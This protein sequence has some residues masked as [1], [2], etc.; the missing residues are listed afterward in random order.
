MSRV[1][2]TGGA[3]FI[4]SRLVR[5]LLDAGR[6][7]TVLDALLP[8]VHG[9]DA[10]PPGALDGARFLRGDVR[11]EAAWREALDDVGLVY[12]LAAETGT[13]ESMY[14]ARRYVDVNVGGTALLCDLLATDEAPAVERVVL[15]SSRAV[16]GEGPYRCP[17]HGVVHPDPRSAERL[18]RGRWEPVCPECGAE[19]TLLPAHAGTR[20]APTSTYGMTKR[21]QEELLHLLLPSLGIE[22]ASLRLQNVYG[23]GQS[24]RNPYTGILSIFSVRFLAGEGVRVFED[25]A[26]SRDFVFVDDVVEAF[27][28]A[29]EVETGPGPLVV[30]VGSGEA[31]SVLRVARALA[32]RYGA[33]EDAVEVTGEYRVGDIRH[34]VAD[35]ARME[36]IL[37]LGKPTGLDEGLDR[38]AGWVREAERPAST[39]DAAL[40]EMAAA[41]LLGRAAP[42]PGPRDR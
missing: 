35:P 19:V 31:V 13:G 41:G 4:G 9:P 11:D 12:H 10:E 39:L 18:S 30:D 5:R 2:V 27:L 40:D 25:G 32:A 1:L 24:L 22:V 21:D 29:G 6:E 36:A 28:R 42:P 16:Y 26:E 7:V 37:A 17:E 3:G 34:A 15:A 8:A 33:P 14:R 20:A 38:L 23:P